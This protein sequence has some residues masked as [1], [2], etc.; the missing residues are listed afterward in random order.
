MFVSSLSHSVQGIT[1]TWIV[2]A[3]SQFHEVQQRK[4]FHPCQETRQLT[5]ELL[6]FG[7]HQSSA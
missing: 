1:G 3:L 6:R 2:F 4:G 7:F 5:A